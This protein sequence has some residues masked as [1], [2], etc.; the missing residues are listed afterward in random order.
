MLNSKNG[1]RTVQ[2]SVR[3]RKLGGVGSFSGSNY[4]LEA[5]ASPST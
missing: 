4:A 3:V 1:D 5:G 2:A